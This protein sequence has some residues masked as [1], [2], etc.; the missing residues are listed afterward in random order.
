[1]SEPQADFKYWAFIS[2]S[3]S[4]Q[5]SAD[6]LHEALERYRVP[7]RLVGRPG[8]DGPVP[9]RIAPI[10]RDREEL[11]TS[12]DLGPRHP[13][14]VA[15]VALP[16]R[17]LLAELRRLDLGQRGGADLQAAGRRQSYSVSHPRRRAERVGQIRHRAGVL[18]PRLAVCPRC[19]RRVERAA[20]RAARRRSSSRPRR[21]VRRAAQAGRRADRHRFRRSQAARAG[22]PA[23]AARPGRGCRA[24]ARPRHR[25][26][27]DGD[28]RLS[29]GSRPPAAHC[30][31]QRG[32]QAVARELVRRRDQDRAGATAGEGERV[33]A[34]LAARADR[35]PRGGARSQP[36]RGAAARPS[37]G[38]RQP[39]LRHR[40]LAAW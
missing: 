29:A 3:H 27:M 16:D 24:R 13:R 40:Q 37:A 31:H 1:M 26:G 21:Q 30:R 4:D 17:R 23:L 32:D 39:R 9:S 2:Y 8:R 22:A 19:R 12:S 28:R 38:G 35:A 7:R 5:A 36:V 18:L 25:R 11:P 6:Q 20:R 33:G 15:R 34:E 10:F 14:G